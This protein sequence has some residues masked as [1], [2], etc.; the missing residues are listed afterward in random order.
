MLTTASSMR[1]APRL[2]KFAWKA[3]LRWD[4]VDWDS[5]QTENVH[6]FFGQELK[7]R[8]T[9]RRLPPKLTRDSQNWEFRVKRGNSRH[10]SRWRASTH[11][12]FPRDLA[13]LRRRM[14]HGSSAPLEP[15]NSI[16][17]RARRGPLARNTRACHPS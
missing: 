17:S 15:A 8:R 4:S 2:R 13:S 11:P 1:F 12:E 14:W 10:I 16:F 5:F 7:H 3:Q 6:G 9:W